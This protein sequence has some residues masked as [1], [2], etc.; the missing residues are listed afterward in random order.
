MS[1]P[2]VS[3]RISNFHL[4]RG[5]RA[6]RILE[7]HW[8][9]TTP[10]DLIRTVFNDYIAKSENLH[11]SPLDV[12]PDLLNEIIQLRISR[13]KKPALD[14][15]AMPALGQSA[16][17]PSAMQQPTLGQPATESRTQH[18]IMLD[19]QAEAIFAETRKEQQEQKNSP[20]IKQS[21]T[22]I[23]IDEQIAL[24]LQQQPKKHQ[25]ASRKIM[26]KAPKEYEDTGSTI[27]TVT[28]FSPPDDWKQ[29]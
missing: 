23:N 29:N 27:T 2:T 15:T 20:P 11:N 9:A 25:E 14:Q 17:Q 12:T 22:D 3:F 10:S 13:A 18:Q 24:A 26:H 1:N 28:D 8:Q 21:A 6:I 5:L 4:A 7:P 16:M 19:E